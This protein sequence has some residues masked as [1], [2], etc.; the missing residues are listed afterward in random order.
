MF[1]EKA[2]LIGILLD[3]F[4]VLGAALQKHIVMVKKNRIYITFMLSE[5]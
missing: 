2:I 3:C 5:K 4:W 1:Y